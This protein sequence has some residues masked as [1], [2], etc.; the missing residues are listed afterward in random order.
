VERK[1]RPAEAK[2]SADEAKIPELDKELFIVEYTSLRGEIVQR[3][4]QQ[5]TLFQIDITAFGIIISYALEKAQKEGYNDVILINVYPFLAFLL[6]SAWGFNQFRIT[7]IATYLMRREN[8]ISGGRGL[9]G[10]ENFVAKKPT[11]GRADGTI[12]T[13]IAESPITIN[14]QKHN[15]NK[16]G[17]MIFNGTQVAS[18]CLAII[19]LYIDFNRNYKNNIEESRNIEFLLICCFIFINFFL[20]YLTHKAIAESNYV[21]EV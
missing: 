3:V 11:Q 9:I 19:M 21:S 1:F 15:K 7:Q 18:I 6:A 4:A 13:Y 12:A 2:V 5:T 10:W 16:P 17:V 8:D 14:L 20:T